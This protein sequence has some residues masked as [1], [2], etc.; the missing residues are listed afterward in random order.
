MITM[1]KQIFSDSY[2]S[3]CYLQSKFKQNYDF[4]M[5]ETHAEKD[6]IQIK[7]PLCRKQELVYRGNHLISLA[8]LWYIPHIT[9]CLSVSKKCLF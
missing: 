8:H 3:L 4:F 5:S 2:G 1:N 7:R 6:N 9:E